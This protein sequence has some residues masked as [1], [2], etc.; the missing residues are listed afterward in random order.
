MPGWGSGT[1]GQTGWGGSAFE[2]SVSASAEAS[3]A[4]LPGVGFV[5]AV[6]ETSAAQEAAASAFSV[7]ASVSESSTGQDTTASNVGFVASVAELSTAQSLFQANQNFFT[8]ISAGASGADQVASSQGFLCEISESGAAQINAMQ[9]GALLTIDMLEESQAQDL[10]VGVNALNAFV[11]EGAGVDDSNAAKVDF[12]AL[13]SE[14]AASQDQ[15]SA[16]IN[17]VAVLSEEAQADD[18]ARVRLLWETIVMNQ[19]TNWRSIVNTPS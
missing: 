17:F 3:D 6:A 9:V 5:S 18:A 12:V 7:G 4:L 16:G 15:I 14:V 1:W 19:E 8:Q 10:V 13:V 11:V 2:V